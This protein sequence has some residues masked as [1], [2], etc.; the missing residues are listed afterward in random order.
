MIPTNNLTS[1]SLLAT[2]DATIS[3]HGKTTTNENRVSTKQQEVTNKIALG[4][5]SGFIL[6]ALAIGLTF[7]AVPIAISLGTG[8]LIGVGL[9]TGIAL[10]TT[11]VTLYEVA[12]ETLHL[13]KEDSN[14]I[15]MQD[16]AATKQVFFDAEDGKDL[17][18][19]KVEEAFKNMALK[20]KDD[21]IPTDVKLFDAE[22]GEGP[23]VEEA[24]INMASKQINDDGIPTDVKLFDAEEGEGPEVE[25]AFIDM[26]SKQINDN[27]PT[28]VEF[29]DANGGGPELDDGFKESTSKDNDLFAPKSIKE[30]LDKLFGE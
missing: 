24:F 12:K 16:F 7:S 18:D 28:D 3:N 11:A 10:I 15:E 4:V 14:E 26:A 13:K 27:I 1:N 29:F 23:E 22:E 30:K 25:E 9:L 19:E 17:E 6:A 2:T 8:A 5:L 20:Q 21:N